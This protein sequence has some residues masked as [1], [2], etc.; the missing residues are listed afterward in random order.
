MAG[1]L[2]PRFDEALAFA[3]RA[4]NSV[5]QERK[6]TDFPY[7]AHPI[8]VAEILD[9]FELDDDVIVAGFLHDTIEDTGVTAEEIGLEFGSPVA[10]LVVAASEADKS[11][12]WKERKQHTLDQLKR[13]TRANVLALVAADKLDNIRSL[14]DTLRHLG[15][16]KT[17]KLFNAEQKQQ[18]W[19]YR[20]V[21]EILLSHD[22]NSRLFRTLD[23][24]AQTLFPD[25]RH[26]TNLFA[27]KP[28]GTPH[29]A[30][31]YLADPIRHWRPDHSAL[32]LAK[33]WIGATGIP[34]S[35]A[36]VLATCPIYA[37]CRLIEGFFEREVDLGTRGRPSQTDLLALVAL[38]DGYG[39]IA[40]E[41][42]TQETFGPIVSEW[43]DSNGKQARLDDLCG[44]LELDPS[45]VGSLRYQLLH[46]TVSALLEARRYGAA[47]ALMLVHSFDPKIS[48]L[49]DYQSFATALGVG[50]AQPN[51]ITRERTLVG[52]ALRLGWV[53]EH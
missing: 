38:T 6:G 43:N 11:L 10:E 47:E 36:S 1:K 34:P 14:S 19:Y 28:L 22:P 40:V 16:E 46:R 41:G 42:K 50:E 26:A 52:I 48:S 9:R 4:H 13:E 3:V 51:G 37:K 33:T 44:R 18:H 17:W 2:N 27:G 23:F 24:E 53:A 29:D 8:R 39:V 25:E 35:V 49:G 15:S 32:E 45:M 31:A 21:V 7:V 5:Q 30:R 20:S 12:P